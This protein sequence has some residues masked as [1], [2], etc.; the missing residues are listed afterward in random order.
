VPEPAEASN[1][2]PGPRRGLLVRIPLLLTLLLPFLVLELAIGYLGLQL[3]QRDLSRQ[4]TAALDEE[5]ARQFFEERATVRDRELYLAEAVTLAA[6]LQGMAAA[7]TNRDPV[8]ARQL[9]DSVLALKSDLVQVAVLDGGALA[10]VEVTREAPGTGPT[11]TAGTDWGA[12]AAVR[13]A[14]RGQPGERTTGL[15]QLGGRRLLVLAEPVC[16]GDQACNGVGVAVA[17]LQLEDLVAPGAAAGDV[18][19]Y[20]SAGRLLLPSAAATSK[21]WPAAPPEATEQR[22]RRVE[23]RG[24]SQLGVL[25]GPL[26]FE[27][28]GSGILAVRQPTAVAYAAAGDT[29]RNLVLVL[30]AAM[31]VT[32]L[33]GSG[34]ARGILRQVQATLRTTRALGS[35]DLAARSPVLAH[36][37]LGDLARGV[38][39]MASQLQTTYETLEQRVEERTAEVRELVGQRSEFFAA[40]SHELRTP[41]AVIVA[42]SEVLHDDSAELSPELIRDSAAIVGRSAQQLLDV[43]NQILEFARTEREGLDVDVRPLALAPVLRGVVAELEPTAKSAGLRWQA[44]IPRRLPQVLAEPAAV[45]TV[46]MNLLGNAVKYTPA[47]GEVTLRVRV[48][49][50]VVLI[51]VADTGVGIP[52]ELGDAVYEPFMR[53]RGTRTQRGEASTGLGLALVRMLVDAIGA[54][55]SY[56]S[57]PGEGTTFAV[58]LRL[59]DQPRPADPQGT[60]AVAT[61]LREPVGARGGPA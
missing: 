28:G 43:V 9:V 25:Y 21:P 58:E 18:A 56:R 4:A 11:T 38:N 22:V 55:I 20:D 19:L 24:Q 16:T 46:L 41:L 60:P 44:S 50:P 35:G 26:A 6:N 14:Q 23:G 8:R 5:L 2:A 36:H 37:E 31:A 39:S 49:D 40:L 47:G 51:E 61:A 32:V 59:A 30:L 1:T 27:G 34:L 53:V 15:V 12:V 13:T 52:P 33:I 42:Q 48:R 54:R 10:L 45:H 29:R 3:L 17:A 7:L 57:T